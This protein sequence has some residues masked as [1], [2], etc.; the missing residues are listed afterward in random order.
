[1]QAEKIGVPLSTLFFETK[2]QDLSMLM[3]RP[4]V[5]RPST[6][7][8]GASIS[9]SSEVAKVPSAS[10]D[11]EKADHAETKTRREEAIVYEDDV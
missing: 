1:M 6:P 3:S 9:V 11:I 5:P 8:T 4:L 10:V 7:P 2:P